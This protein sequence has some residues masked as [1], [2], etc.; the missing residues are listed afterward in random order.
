MALDRYHLTKRKNEWRLEKAGSDRALVKAPTKAEAVQKTRRYM[1]T[2]KGSVRIHKVN[3]KI[4][5]S[6]PLGAPEIRQFLKEAKPEIRSKIVG[7]WSERRASAK[8]R[9]MYEAQEAAQ[10][11]AER[12]EYRAMQREIAR[13]QKARGPWLQ[14]NFGGVSFEFNDNKARHEAAQKDAERHYYDIDLYAQTCSCDDFARRNARHPT[15]DIRRLCEHLATIIDRRSLLRRHSDPLCQFIVEGCLGDVLGVHTGQLTD[16][17]RFGVVVRCWPDVAVAAPRVRDDGFVRTIWR[18]EN[19]A[20]TSS[21]C[22]K[23]YK[24][25]LAQKL[26]EL[27]PE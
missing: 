8:R 25:E 12:R 6:A 14:A 13:V 26:A 4:H 10:E 17:K 19:G 1:K 20:W 27:L 5:G 9:K 11:A 16:G 2:R 21:K 23:R 15:G 7:L 24:E 18:F 3:G 22:S